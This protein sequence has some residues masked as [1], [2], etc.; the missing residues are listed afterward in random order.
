MTSSHTLSLISAGSA[1]T[2]RDVLYAASCS[3]GRWN[4]RG[5]TAQTARAEHAAHLQ[6]Y[7]GSEAQTARQGLSG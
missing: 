1:S 5:V 3:C 6:V 4:M 2:R 7:L